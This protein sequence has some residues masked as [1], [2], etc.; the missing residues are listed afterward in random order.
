MRFC[1]RQDCLATAAN[2]PA[3]APP[4]RARRRHLQ[5]GNSRRPAL[6]GQELGRGGKA[7]G[8][9]CSLRSDAPPA[10]AAPPPP[11]ATR[12]VPPPPLRTTP[13]QQ[14]RRS[15]CFPG[16]GRQP[17]ASGRGQSGRAQTGRVRAGVLGIFLGHGPRGL[18]AARGRQAFR[19]SPSAAFADAR[20]RVPRTS[21]PSRSMASNERN[22]WWWRRW[23]SGASKGEAALAS[24]PPL[25][26]A[27]AEAKWMQTAACQPCT[28][29]MGHAGAGRPQA[30][31]RA[32]TDK[33]HSRSPMPSTRSEGSVPLAC[34]CV[35]RSSK[36]QEKPAPST[37][38]RRQ[39]A[40]PRRSTSFRKVKS[41]QVKSSEA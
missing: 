19:G 28:R 8:P 40:P 5:A 30:P 25:A 27:A 34:S 2:R 4:A 11:A 12:G 24:A 6:Q 1:E 31:L 29:D 16:C 33:S 10:R 17:L 3:A 23:V 22:V 18:P 41:S 38:S 7:R 36:P 20:V 14:T 21:A 37:S 35:Q 39:P 9:R 13:S 15:R 26:H 32:P